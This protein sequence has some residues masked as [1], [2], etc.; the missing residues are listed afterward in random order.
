MRRFGHDGPC[1]RWLSARP[2]HD[3][4]SQHS[5]H[6][7]GTGIKGAHVNV[8]LTSNI[9]I[10]VLGVLA[11]WLQTRRTQGKGRNELRQDLDLYNSLPQESDSRDRLLEHIDKQIE[12]LIRR[13][14]ELSRD[15]T[16]ISLAIFLLLVTGALSVAAVRERGIWWLLLVPALFFGITASVGLGEDL[17]RRKRDERGRPIKDKTRRREAGKIATPEDNVRHTSSPSSQLPISERAD[18]KSKVGEADRES[19]T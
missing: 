15:P 16:G 14:D 17:P 2:H 7:S 3:P 13:E 4:T 19:D 12:R 18:V 1:W 10:A 6:L 5:G 9:V 11:A 8:T